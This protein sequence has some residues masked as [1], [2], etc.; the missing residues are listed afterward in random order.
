MVLTLPLSSVKRKKQNQ[1]GKKEP[2]GEA[3]LYNVFF[4]AVSNYHLKKSVPSRFCI[5][6]FAFFL[7]DF[8]FK[9]S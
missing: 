5:H 8:D 7:R 1:L 2:E 4:K 3:C 9:F 6:R